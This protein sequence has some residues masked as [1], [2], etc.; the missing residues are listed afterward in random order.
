MS[1]SP[2]NIDEVTYASPRPLTTQ[3]RSRSGAVDASPEIQEHLS[4]VIQASKLPAKQRGV[5]IK[6]TVEKLASLSY[7]QGLLP[8]ELNEL[9]D[10]VTTP[11]FLD[12][13]N[14]GVIIRNL[15]PATPVSDG[16]VIKVVGCLGHGKLKPSLTV[17]AALLRWL[18]LIQHVMN[19][20]TVLF[21]TYPVL[22]NLLD[23]AGLR[24]YVCHLLAL[25]TRRRH[26]RPHRIQTLLALSR[27]TGN[28]PPLTG[29][30]RVYKDYYPEI[31]VGEATR[32]K[33]SAF[34]HPD[35]QWRERLDEIR[36]AHAQRHASRSEMPLDA[37]RVVRH[38]LNGT[39]KLAIPEVHTSY[40]VES[41]TTLEEIENVDGFVKNL[42]KIDLPNQL[43]AILGDPLLQ[44]FL[45]L[46]PQSDA[47]RRA[48]NWL[49]SYAQDVMSGDS[50]VHLVDILKTLQ[51][52]VTAIKYLPPVMLSF[53]S[54]LLIVWDGKDG[55]DL[56]LDVLTFTPI[57][58]FEELKAGIFLP[59]ER[60]M[61][62]GSSE[63]QIELLHFF[64]KLLRRWVVC[65]KS[66]DSTQT[67]ASECAAQLIAHANELCLTLLQTWPDVSSQVEIL[68][69]Y[70]QASSF[71]SDTHLLRQPD[72]GSIP[73]PPLVY[74]LFFAP[75]PIIASRMCSV[76]AK[77]KEGFQLA[78]DLTGATSTPKYIAEYNSFLMDI[79]NC[80][81]RSRAF[82]TKD[83]SANGCLIGRA[84]VDDLNSY[85]ESLSTGGSLATLFSLSYSSI[86]GLMAIS[87][88]REVEENEL[89]NGSEGLDVRHAG[90]VTRKSLA[91][92]ASRGGVRLA[93]DDYRLGVLNHLDSQGMVGVGQLLSNTMTT[94]MQRKP[95]L[96]AS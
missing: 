54:E 85:V 49:Q 34:K 6:P 56:I 64:T 67:H 71:A 95:G 66:S 94:L 42:D 33:A 10:L 40:A 63:S 45:L 14:L 61:L 32:G 23:T 87:H 84:I 19:R 25:I 57:V 12:Q 65:L 20:Q 8:T 30:L 31:I 27:Q 43:I 78:M 44:K 81:W 37:F 51:T 38:R 93:W 91:T 62:D 89:E 9:I 68:N 88:L 46:R 17:Q 5:N 53:F 80:L 58:R 72:N 60:K 52:Y 7:D 55:K 28:D 15:Y 39:K 36:R 73:P 22:F 29:L 11:S 21:Q 13:A 47:H 48:C 74:A 41:S 4:E 86:F 35:P 1:L 59:L 50:D 18:I 2:N 96:P 77:Y 69:F 26:V 3:S 70:D 83:A 92:L 75:T 90:P 82:S 76:V 16:V 79:C 24:P